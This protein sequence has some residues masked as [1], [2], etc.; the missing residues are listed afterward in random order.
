MHQ[1][2]AVP[3]ASEL[4]RKHPFARTFCSENGIVAISFAKPFAIA[5]G[6]IRNAQFATFSL[7]FGGQNSLPTSRSASEFAFAAVSLRPRRTQFCPLQSLDTQFLEKRV[8]ESKLNWCTKITSRRSLAIVHRRL[9][10]RKEFHNGNQFV[11]FNC[12]EIVVRY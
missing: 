1:A 2:V 10:Y 9:R 3:I 7:R 5:S 11:S 6:L 12:K 8:L 4:C